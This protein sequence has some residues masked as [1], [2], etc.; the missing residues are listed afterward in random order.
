MPEPTDEMTT[1]IAQT[2][3]AAIS[4]VR[5]DVAFSNGDVMSAA[6]HIL[7][8]AG[9]RSVE[10]GRSTREE[11]IKNISDVAREIV[12]RWTPDGSGSMQ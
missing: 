2:M 11:L 7:V 3:E 5:D 10:D 4:R 6:M 12:S 9:M 8:D 1:I